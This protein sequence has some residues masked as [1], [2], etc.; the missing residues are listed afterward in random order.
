MADTT[1]IEWADHTFSPWLGCTPVSEACDHCY[2]KTMMER[3][4]RAQYAAGAPRVR[5]AASTWLQ[6]RRWNAQAAKRGK[7]E[8]VF[9][10]LC[11][12]FDP[13]VDP[14]WRADYMT[15][16]EATSHLDHL[17][18]TKRPK[19]AY[20]FFEGRSVP[21]NM[22][23]GITAESQPMLE[24]RSHWVQRIKARRRFIS[25]EPMRGPMNLCEVEDRKL[26]AVRDAA[27]A[28]VLG[29][30]RVYGAGSISTTTIGTGRFHWVIAGGESGPGAR[31]SHPDWFRVL[32]NQ[33]LNAGVPFF[34]K[35][36]GDWLPRIDRDT[37]DPDWRLDYRI[38]NPRQYQHL[39][40][41]GGQGFHGERVHLMKRVGKKL[42]GAMLDGR[43]HREFP[44]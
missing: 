14:A 19:V 10:S 29:E 33:C 44:T 26:G 41:A 16:I 30:L 1:A 32:R 7:R 17:V 3:Y 35:Q 24:L 15:L 11:D 18:L 38:Q 37:Y 43:E 22:A 27:V 5:T 4:G 8:S 13:E 31:P 42:A 21:D 9:P 25:I 2:A 36:W 6:V 34:F 39:N 40:R 20:E 12:P 23:L 28:E